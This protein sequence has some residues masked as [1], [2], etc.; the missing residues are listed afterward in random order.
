VT[1]PTHDYRD[2]SVLLNVTFKSNLNLEFENMRIFVSFK[3][4]ANQQQHAA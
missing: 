1:N 2:L 4:Q 3:Q